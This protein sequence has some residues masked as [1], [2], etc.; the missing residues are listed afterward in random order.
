MS[1]SLAQQVLVRLL[2][3]E[4]GSG[5]TTTQAG[6][7]QVGSTAAATKAEQQK[8]FSTSTPVI[9]EL[10]LGTHEEPSISERLPFHGLSFYPDCGVV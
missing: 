6:E 9:L 3:E 1:N 5:V 10:L 8:N 4:A 2:Q 7:Q